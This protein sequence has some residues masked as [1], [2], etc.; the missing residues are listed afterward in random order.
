MLSVDVISICKL[1]NLQQKVI[2][3]LRQDWLVPSPEM[4][5][6]SLKNKSD[7]W[8]AEIPSAA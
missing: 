1:I 2:G 8:N 6:S 7:V 5:I 3:N 4:Q